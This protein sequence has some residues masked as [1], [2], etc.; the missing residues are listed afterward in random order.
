[1]ENA[2]ALAELY[3][4]GLRLS[5]SSGHLDAHLLKAEN[6]W[7]PGFRLLKLPVQDFARPHPDS[8]APQCLSLSHGEGPLSVSR[9]VV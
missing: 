8:I 4:P 5:G 7:T 2:D 6:P 1:M 9:R 3:T